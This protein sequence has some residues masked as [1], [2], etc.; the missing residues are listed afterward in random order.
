MN[1]VSA[2]GLAST[3]AIAAAGIARAEEFR[4]SN[5]MEPNHPVSIYGFG[6]WSEEVAKETGGDVIFQVFEGGSLIPA[7]TTLQGVADGVAQVGFVSANYTPSLMPIAAS[8]GDF[9]F[10]N[11][12][13]YVL[14]AAY[15]DFMMN[16]PE[17]SREWREGGVVY[18]AGYGTPIYYF[19]CREPL[20]TAQDFVGKRIRTPGG[21]L[22]RFIPTIG[23]VSVNIT[24]TETYQAFDRG[25]LDCSV[26]DPT[27][28][29]GG[30]TLM[31]VTKAITLLPMAPSFSG[32][33]H[34]YDLE[35]WSDL[36]DEERRGILNA[37]ARSM[38]RMNIASEKAAQAALEVAREKGIEM[39]EPDASLTE[40]LA[41]WV[42]GGM[43]D[44]PEAEKLGITDPEALFEQFRSYLDK[45][46]VVF[47]AMKDRLDEDEYT[48][49]LRENLYD[50]IDVKSYG[51]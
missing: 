14:S 31:D 7:K 44:V 36:T 35:F 47:G 51:M 46:D 16:D 3:L 15:S 20:R 2:L 40:A 49:M 33:L 43:G 9:E 11:T 23:A 26:N 10:V 28:L 6:Q 38:A 37:E 32:A 22:P 39:V 48:A 4:A 18:G 1:V 17:A 13:P 41:T 34:A 42:N 45:W 27:H 12:D 29:T 30:A 24:S 19:L 25:A 8:L 50:E 21:G 5:W